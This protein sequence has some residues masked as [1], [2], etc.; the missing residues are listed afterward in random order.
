MVEPI[1]FKYKK[2][3]SDSSKN[4][5][6]KAQVLE[7]LE[8]NISAHM[9]SWAKF[10]Q[11][12][13]NRA[14]GYFKDLDKYCI[15]MFLVRD[16]WQLLAD[17]FVYLSLDEYY[18][19]DQVLI[20]RINLLE[21]SKELN[22]P[23]ETIRRKVNEL[24][25]DGLLSRQGKTILFTRSALNIQQPTKTIDLLALF[26]EKKSE[27]IEGYDWF[28]EKLNRE[29]IKGFINKYFTVIWLRFFK[30]QMPYLIR[31]RNMFEDLETW[32][33]WGN[34]A[35]SNQYNLKKAVTE[36]LIEED[37]KLSDYYRNITNIDLDHGLSA[38]SISDISHIPR[39]TVI[40]KLKWLLKKKVIK[41]N[42]DLQYTLCSE[43]KLNKNIS[44]NLLINQNEV[45]S[46]LADTFDL[47]KNSK[48]KS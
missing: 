21:T 10:Q 48:F 39:A 4:K 25:K 17:K 46:F 14:Y 45:A 18:S 33:V 8:Q 30:L 31:Q 35:I 16:N 47:L 15:L 13:T 29:Q 43:G 20:E 12:W 9:E 6:N 27:A 11:T 1:D 19:Q 42:K 36:K 22:I 24:Q 5:F 23:K 28:G 41:K 38:S 3:I 44:N 26:I 2:L 32:V 7:I 37:I 40:R 34:V